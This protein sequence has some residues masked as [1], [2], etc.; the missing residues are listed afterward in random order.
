MKINKKERMLHNISLTEEMLNEEE[1]TVLISFASK[2]PVLREFGYEIIDVNKMNFSRLNNKAMLLFN[3]NWNDYIG[4]I[5]KVYIENERA[6]AKVKFDTHQRANQIFDSIKNGVIANVS[7][8]YE[9]N[10]AIK[11]KPINNNDAYLVEITPFEVSFVSVPADF[12]VGFMRSENNNDEKIEVEKDVEI[13]EKDD[14]KEEKDDDIKINDKI[15]T[16]TLEIDKKINNNIDININLKEKSMD[17]EVRQAENKKI[18]ETAK[19]YNAVELAVDYIDTRSHDEFLTDLL[20]QRNAN[21]VKHNNSIINTERQYDV[22]DALS[23][24]LVANKNSG[25]NSEIQSELR[26]KHRSGLKHDNSFFIEFAQKRDVMTS[27]P[28]NAGNLIEKVYRPDLNVIYGLDE[29]M[30]TKAGATIINGMEGNLE[31]LRDK[32]VIAPEYVAE[33][34]GANGSNLSLEKVVVTP[35][36]VTANVTVTHQMLKQK[37]TVKALI[38]DKLMQKI[39][40]QIDSDSINGDGSGESVLGLLNTTGINSIASATGDIDWASVVGLEGAVETEN[41]FGIFSYIGNSKL[42]SALKTTTK[43]VNGGFIYEN[44]NIVNGNQYINSNSIKTVSNKTKLIFGDFS[45]LYVSLWGGI[46]VIV[47]PYMGTAGTVNVIAIAMY[48]VSVAKPDAFAV[49]TDINVN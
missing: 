6:Y 41:N 24:Y 14:E 11:A 46:E 45:K 39:Y 5:E 32:N 43:S 30:L 31:Y 34:Q 37:S 22:V 4:V 28:T 3:H 38:I 9:I 18:M 26:S 27:Q 17:Y 25:L 47:N 40:S 15:L 48:N 10:R 19:Q 23:E 29:L 44:G 16:K 2:E 1:R 7:F 49:L 13:K 12:S 8:G 33:G 21:P 35:K 42:K 36:T 20:K